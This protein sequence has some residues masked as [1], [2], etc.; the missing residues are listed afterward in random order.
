M[1][2]CQGKTGARIEFHNEYVLS[3]GE[4]QSQAAHHFDQVIDTTTLDESTF[5]LT[6]PAPAQIIGS[7]RLISGD[8][9]PSTVSVQGAWGFTTN[10]SNQ[11]VATFTPDKPL[12]QNTV[13]TAMLLGSDAALTS[14]VI[15]NPA[16]ESMTVSYSWGF[17]T[18]VLNLH[19]RS[20]HPAEDKTL[21]CG[22]K[23]GG[24]RTLFIASVEHRNA[25]IRV[26]EEHCIRFSETEFT[27]YGQGS[28]QTLEFRIDFATSNDGGNAFSLPSLDT[29]A[30]L[31]T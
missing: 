13:Y 10:A 30:T 17:T 5:S 3:E 9:A 12:Q 18:G 24:F 23:G 14:S 28:F 19:T 6:F 4:N 16:G 22:R 20:L 25:R 2:A 26:P 15:E 8:P 29:Y 7:N 11:T 21:A 1:R 31:R 27:F